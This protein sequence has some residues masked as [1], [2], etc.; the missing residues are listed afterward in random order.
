MHPL[1]ISAIPQLFHG[2]RL[3]ILLPFLNEAEIIVENTQKVL[4]ISRNW[5]LEVEIVLIDD[6]STDGSFQ[7]LETAFHSHPQIRL[8][9]NHQNFG[10]G[11]AL[12]T[13][14]EY[15]RGDYILFL[16]SDLE[17]SP[18]HLP[19]FFQIMQQEQSD[20]V[21]GSKMHPDS[22]LDY[23]LKR[24]IM[25]RVYYLVTRLFFG[26]KVRDTQT[27]IKLFRRE[28][29]ETALPRMMVKRFAFDIELLLILSRYGHRVASA[30]IELNFSRVAAGRMKLSTVF[31]ML[32]DTLAI[33]YRNSFL[34]YYQ[35]ALG[36]NRHYSYTFVLF[37][38][39]RDEFETNALRNFLSV[40][41]PG[42]KFVY[43]G[44]EEPLLSDPRL[45]TV[46]TDTTSFPGA[47]QELRHQIELDT[48]YVIFSTLD[49][50]P[51][52]R[53]LY[54]A[55]RVLSQDHVDAVSG[56]LTLR[57]P[58]SEFE[59]GA[60]TCIR[61]VFLNLKLNYRYQALH[62]RLIPELSLDGMI[63]PVPVVR[64]LDLSD[65]SLRLEHIISQTLRNQG[66]QMHYVPDLLL[67][68]RFPTGW[69]ELMRFLKTHARSRVLHQTSLLWLLIA[70]LALS[71]SLIMSI[72]YRQFWYSLPLILYVVSLFGSRIILYGP[73][74][75]V[76]WGGMLLWS[77]C[78]YGWHYIAGWFRPRP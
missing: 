9:H 18:L 44:A 20:A 42:L 62:P 53:F 7:K 21:I 27:G 3:S 6:G 68:K 16:D 67:Y 75:G 24:K 50:Y 57:H 2:S 37:S 60:Y 39:R 59:L 47:L 35:R 29:L 65:T 19:G 71:G 28:C 31:N 13:G 46:L 66:R 63:V 49:T 43:C 10:K 38:I 55:G 15:S 76:R 11:W 12:K 25:S 36:E 40:N 73:V 22:I 77:Q 26:L 4:E 32:W 5:D 54:P 30:P 23:P 70:L 58:H 14:F 8:V 48:D 41:Y 74:R 1:K 33:F 52:E 72:I 34:N 61:S 64:D 51:D 69:Q 45:Q 78:I 17:L 56:Y